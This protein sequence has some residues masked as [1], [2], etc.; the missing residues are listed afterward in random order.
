MIDPQPSET[1]RLIAFDL[2]DTVVIDPFFAVVPGVTGMT[3]DELFEVAHPT[4]WL[5]FERG[6]IDEQ[7][8]LGRFYRSGLARE[9][10]PAAQIV[11][12]VLDNYRFV[13]GME[14]L[15]GRLRREDLLLY[16]LSNYTVWVDHVREAL[17]LDRFFDDYVVSF[18][19]GARKP[20]PEAY[21]TLCQRA[22]LGPG[23]CLLIDDRRA[24][25]E[26][27]AAIG[28]PA[29]RFRHAR[30]LEAELVG[31]GLLSPDA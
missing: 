2:M 14:R 29:L 30:Q 12:T 24:N 26:G 27:A 20:E 3:L 4:S 16:V 9:V 31:R 17:K 25:V 18:Q 22:G 15:L 13:G 11:R 7:T 28:M 21:Q 1:P 5:E 23:R 8:F 6:E 10:P 19:T